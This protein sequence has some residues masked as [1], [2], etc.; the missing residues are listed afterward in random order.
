MIIGINH[1]CQTVFWSSS[2]EGE[3]GNFEFKINFESRRIHTPLEALSW[4]DRWGHWDSL[5][6]QWTSTWNEF[7]SGFIWEYAATSQE[8]GEMFKWT[9]VFGGN[10]Q[11]GLSHLGLCN[12]IRAQTQHVNIDLATSEVIGY[13]WESIV[14]WIKPSDPL[15]SSSSDRRFRGA[16][17]LPESLTSR[18]YDT[19]SDEAKQIDWFRNPLSSSTLTA[20]NIPKDI[21]R[22]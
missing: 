12:D 1:Q 16:K 8:A 10:W 19:V 2:G 7:L 6:D 3:V 11:Q 20:T 13:R 5:D 17:M 4:R 21:P 14:N 22:P 15:S 9:A 18:V